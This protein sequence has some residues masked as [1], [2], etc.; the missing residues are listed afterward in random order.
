MA[1]ISGEEVGE[2]KEDAGAILLG[3]METLSSRPE[4]SMLVMEI[5]VDEGDA[6][7]GG[8]AKLDNLALISSSFSRIIA[9]IS[10]SVISADIFVPGL[11]R[12]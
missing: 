10:S 8:F 3:L 7:V 1:S 5:R 2:A 9:N 4:S 12:L 11:E 6:D